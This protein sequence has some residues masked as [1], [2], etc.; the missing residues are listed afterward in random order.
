MIGFLGVG[1]H[2]RVLYNRKDKELFGERM[3]MNEGFVKEKHM[4]LSIL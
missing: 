1:I 3:F 2:G 4:F